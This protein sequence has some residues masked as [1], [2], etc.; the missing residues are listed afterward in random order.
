MRK[1]TDLLLLYIENFKLKH[2]IVNEGAQERG[3]GRG[4]PAS[5]KVLI[6]PTVIAIRENSDMHAAACTLKVGTTLVE[7]GCFWK[8]N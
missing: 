6:D 1:L 5:R 2:E 8:R 4:V 3:V 7:K